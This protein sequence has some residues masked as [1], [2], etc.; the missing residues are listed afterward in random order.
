MKV[1]REGCGINISG[2]LIGNKYYEIELFPWAGSKSDPGLYIY[3]QL[4]TKCDHEGFSC[5]VSV[6]KGPMFD[7]SIY[8]HRHWNYD[9]E[10]YEEYENEV[11]EVYE[12]Y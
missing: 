5:G 11:P 8:D 10:D 9:Y 1:Y 4:K 2:H 12:L 3:A 7:F 6:G